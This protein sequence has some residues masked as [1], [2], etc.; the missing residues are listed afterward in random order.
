MNTK[1]LEKLKKNIVVDQLHRP[2]LLPQVPNRIICLVPSITELLYNL[3]LGDRV[4][5]ITKFCVHPNEWFTTKTRIGGTKTVNLKKIKE[6]NPDLIIAN[7][8]ENVQA[9]VEALAKDFPVY[10]SAIENLEQALEMIMHIGKLTNTIKKA[11]TIINKIEQNFKTLP[12]LATKEKVAYLIWRNPYITI[13]K[14]TFIQD[15]L[16]RMSLKNA[17][18]KEKRYPT[19]TIEYLQKKNP[20]YIFLSSEPYPFKEK[21]IAEL[22]VQLPKA[23]ILLVDGE[24]FSWYGSRLLKSVTYFKKLTK[25]LKS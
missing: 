14:D 15:M 5:G 10:I 3:G 4:I 22:Q 24:L 19:I 11:T 17:F 13:G 25:L 6:L 8:E 16:T 1:V 7:K 23:K 20:N 12:V 2:I 9:Q 18:T 21:H